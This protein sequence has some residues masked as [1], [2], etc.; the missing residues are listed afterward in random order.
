MKFYKINGSYP[1]SSL[2][3]LHTN[4]RNNKNYQ[5]KPKQ[6][7]IR[8]YKK[9]IKALNCLTKILTLSVNKQKI[10]D[11]ILKKLN[12]LIINLQKL[13]VNGRCI[14]N[15]WTNNTKQIKC[16]LDRIKLIKKIDTK[17]IWMSKFSS[18][19]NVN[20]MVNYCKD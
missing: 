10:L 20:K 6:T 14:Q 7:L 12:K 13:K 8:Y 11:K 3:I 2:K 16:S 1:K 9:E 15:L 5:T 19:I 18:E 4:K 17:M